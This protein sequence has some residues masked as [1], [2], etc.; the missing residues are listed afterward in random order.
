MTERVADHAAASAAF[1]VLADAEGARIPTY[2]RLCRIIAADPQLHGLLLEA[3]TGQR[4]PVLVL[5]ALH[6][7]VLRRPDLPLAA[8]YP[9]VTGDEPSQRDP[10]D[11]LIHA[12]RAHRDEI[13]EV[14][15]TRRIQTNEVNRSCAWRLGLA[16]ATDGDDRPLAL[17]ELGASAGLN[18]LLD[19]FSY[20]FDGEPPIDV[21]DPTSPVRLG[22]TRHPGGGADGWPALLEAPLP[23]IVARVGIDQRPVDPSDPDDARW[24]AACTWPEQTIRYERMSAAVALA[25]EDPSEIRRGDLVDDLPLLLEEL[26]DGCHVVVLSSWVL[27][28]LERRR[29]IELLDVLGSASTSILATGGRLS[30][31]TFEAGNVLPWV[32]VPELGGDASA[33]RRTA[34]TLAHTEVSGDGTAVR[35]LARCQAHMTWWEALTG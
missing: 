16:A 8:W 28:Y 14:I 22:T 32:G 34:T 30:L 6:D 12:V 23:P 15:R 13:V 18:L 25:G 19:R 9:S 20:R 29:R 26:P 17:V 1:I 4:L 2:A 27:V 33:D 5:A 35:A 10:T 11:A 24:L 21:G 31:L 7:L 3:P